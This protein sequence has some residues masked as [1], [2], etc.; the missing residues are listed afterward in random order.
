MFVGATGVARVL[1]RTAALMKEHDTAEVG[2]FGGID[3]ATVQRYVNFHCSVSLDLFGAETSTNAANY[4][5]AGL[6]GRFQEERRADDHRLQHATRTMAGVDGGELCEREV[7]ELAALN[8]TLRDDFL[9]DCRKGVDRWNRALAEVGMEVRLPHPGF[10]RA[11]GAFAG[12]RI[13]PAGDVLTESQWA[14]RRH[15]WLPTEDDQAHV[16]SLMRPVQEPGQMAGWVAPPGTG[17]HQKP[18]EYAYVSV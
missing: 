17:I 9:A 14:A 3:V 15:E 6:K 5:A 11:V 13:S 7:S 8:L 12:H 4:F 16:R 2:P 18:V 1:Q 10:N